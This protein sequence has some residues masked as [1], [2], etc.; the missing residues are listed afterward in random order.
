MPQVQEV[1]MSMPQEDTHQAEMNPPPEE[2]KTDPSETEPPSTPIRAACH[3]RTASDAW[4]RTDGTPRSRVTHAPSAD[5][6]QFIGGNTDT[7][8]LGMRTS[9][10]GEKL[11][12]EIEDTLQ[13]TNYR[14]IMKQNNEWCMRNGSEYKIDAWIKD[15][16]CIEVVKERFNPILLAIGVILILGG[17]VNYEELGLHLSSDYQLGVNIAPIGFYLIGL[18]VLIAGQLIRRTC[19]SLGVLGQTNSTSFQCPIQPGDLCMINDLADR[20]RRLQAPYSTLH[21][22]NTDTT[23]T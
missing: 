9:L 12:T 14:I 19:L 13:L 10:R 6:D 18:S 7:V 23:E 22:G 1:E 11:I 20:L 17:V 2:T 5:D 8:L 4:F 3:A 21:Y 16:S 15:I